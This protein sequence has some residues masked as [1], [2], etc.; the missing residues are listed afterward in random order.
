MPVA[1]P[2][3]P[4]GNV[5]L[6]TPPNDPPTLQDVLR[7]RK[8]AVQITIDNKNRQ[9]NSATDEDAARAYVYETKIMAAHLPHDAEDD[10]APAWFAGAL[11]A[12]LATALPP[13]L[14]RAL[15]PLTK[16][17]SQ[18]HNQQCDD[19]VHLQY[20]VLPFTDGTFPTDQEHGLPALVNVNSIRALTGP[21]ASAYLAGYGL[22]GVHAIDERKRAI[23]REIGCPVKVI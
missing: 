21:Q 1:L 20:K 2:L 16:T 23:G 4:V 10:Q 22:P 19:G 9:L 8:Y 5:Q 6:P 3:Q 7:A 14:T 11:A 15:A 17:I 13:L 12:G 18:V